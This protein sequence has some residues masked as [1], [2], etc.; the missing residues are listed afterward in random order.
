MAPG[1]ASYQAIASEIKTPEGENIK[2]NPLAAPNGVSVLGGVGTSLNPQASV[3]VPQVGGVQASVQPNVPA[4]NAVVAANGPTVAPIALPAPLGSAG[5]ATAVRPEAA[6]EASQES[7]ALPTPQAT[8]AGDG[9]GVAPGVTPAAKSIEGLTQGDSA[10]VLA[11]PKAEKSGVLNWIFD[12]FKGKGSQDG[13]EASEIAPGAAKGAPAQRLA[14]PGDLKANL[15][16]GVPAPANVPSVAPAL[17]PARVYGVV[18]GTALAVAAVTLMSAS[19]VVAL[20]LPIIGWGVGGLL[21]RGQNAPPAEESG[22]ASGT[23]LG[24]IAAAA[25]VAGG[26]MPISYALLL[27]LAGAFIGYRIGSA[28]KPAAR[29]LPRQEKSTSLKMLPP[30]EAEVAAEAQ[31][32][33]A[34]EAALA[35]PEEV[36]KT[37]AAPAAAKAEEQKPVSQPSAGTSAGND[38]TKTSGTPRSYKNLPADAREVGLDK[39]F[40]AKAKAQD[41]A[42]AIAQNAQLVGVAINLEDP[43][44]HWIFTFQSPSQKI[45]VYEKS[46]K[47]EPRQKGEKAS[48]VLWDTRFKNAGNLEAA[49]TSL[50][51]EKHWFKPA[52]VELRPMWKGDPYYVFTDAQGREARVEAP[53]TAPPVAPAAPAKVE[54]PVAAPQPAAVSNPGNGQDKT[55]GSTPRS[56]RNLPADAREIGLDKLFEAKAKAQDRAR[57][58][59]K[60]AQ[61]IGVAINLDNPNAHWIFTFQSKSRKIT[62][63]EKNVKV[64]RLKA[65]EKAKPVLWN[66]RFKKAGGLEAAYTALKSEKHWFKPVRVELRP[67]WNGDPYYLFIDAQG[68]EARV[69]ATAAQPAPAPAKTP[70]S[71]RAPPEA[72][73]TTAPGQE[74]KAPEPVAAPAA[75]PPENPPAETK[76]AVQPPAGPKYNAVREDF[77]GFRK[78]VGQTYAKAGEP[79]LGMLPVNASVPRIIEQISRQF[80]IPREKVLEMAAQVGFNEKSPAKVWF[81]IYDRLQQANREQFKKLDHNKYEG[82][83]GGEVFAKTLAL[84]PMPKAW[85]E[86]LRKTEGSYRHL[87]N[88]TY[89]PGL[90]GM[91]IR[92]SEVHK[93]FLGFFVR[94]PYHL[95]DSFVFGYFRQNISFEYLHSTQD[96]LNAASPGSGVKMLEAAVR[97]QAFKGD[98]L[99]GAILG[100]AWGRAANRYLVAPLLSPLLTFLKRRVTMAVFSAVAMGILGAFAPGIAVMSFG[101]TAIPFV[102]PAMVGLAHGIPVAVGSVPLI[103]SLLAPVVGAATMALLKDMV[104]GRLLNTMIL[105]TGM[106]LT[107]VLPNSIASQRIKLQEADPKARISGAQATLKTLGSGEFWWTL[108]KQNW[109]SFVGLVTVGAEIEGIMTYAGGVDAHVTS[110]IGHKFTLLEKIG[111]SIER[112]AGQSPIPFGGAITW[113]NV[114]LLKAENLLHLNISDQVMYAINPKLKH[115]GP[116]GQGASAQ[117]V[118]QMTTHR[119]DQADKATK[120]KDGNVKDS[121]TEFDKDLYTKTPAKIKARIE[122]LMAQSGGLEAEMK[123]VKDWQAFIQKK[124]SADEQ[125]VADIQKQSKPITPEERAQYEALLKELTQKRE[126]GYDKSKLA[127]VHDIKNP[128]AETLPKMQELKALQEYYNSHLVPPSKD[129]PG[130]LD[131]LNVQQASLGALSSHLSDIALN[132]APTRDQGAVPPV[133]PALKD[134]ITAIVDKIEKIRQES[135]GEMANRDAIRQLLAVENKARNRALDDRRSGKDMLALHQNMSRLATVMD[136]ALALNE[137]TAAE[138]AISQMENLLNQ[139]L[140]AIQNS[141]QQNQQ[142][143]NTTNGQLGQVNQWTQAA[144]AVVTSDQASQQTMVTNEAEAGGAVSR[145]GGFQTAISGLIAQIN[146]QDKGQSASAAAEYQR[147]L[148]LLPQVVQW[149]TTGNPNNPSA[150]SLTQFQNLLTQIQSSIATAQSGLNQLPTVPVEFAGALI[151]LIPG[152]APGYSIPPSPSKAQTLQLLADRKTYWTGQMGTIQ[153][154]LNTITA[155]MNPANTATTTDEFGNVTPQSLPVWLQQEQTLLGTSQGQAQTMLAQIDQLAADVNVKLGASLPPLS[156]LPLAQLQTALQ[157]Y[158]TQV[159]AVNVPVNE[160]PAQHAASLEILYIAQLMPQAAHNVINWS[161]ASATITQINSAMA[162]T[163]PQAKSKLTEMVTMFQNILSDDAQDVAFVNGTSGETNQQ[164]VNRKTN[165]LQ[166]E[167]LPPLNDAQALL[168][169]VL[170]PYQQSSIQSAQAGQPLSQLFNAQLTLI[171]QSTNLYNQTIPWAIASHG[172]TYGNQ[173]ASLASIAAWRAQLQ[174]N[175]SNTDPNNLGLLQYQTEIQN[176]VNPNFAGTEVLYGETQPYSLPKKIAQY[177]GEMVT[178]AAAINADDAQINSILTQIQTVSNGQYNMQSYL[179]PTGITSD[180]AG[181]AKVQALVNASTIPNLAAQ[182]KTIGNSAN[183]SGGIS[184]PVGGGGGAVPVGTQPPITVSNQQKIALL[185]LD[186]AR[187]LAPSSLQVQNPSD[188]SASYAVARFLYSNAVVTSA[189]NYMAPGGEIQ[190]AT[191]F[192]NDGIKAVNDAI[193]NTQSDQSY[194]TSN[195]SSESPD[196]VYQREVASY[197]ELDN[198]LKEGIAFFGYLTTQDQGAFATINQINTYYTSLQ[199]IYQGGQSANAGEIQAYQQMTQALQSTLTTLQADQAKVLAY[200]S[201]LDDPHDSA[202]RRINETI[203]TLQDKTRAVLEQNIK[204][205]DLQDQ[206]TRSEDVMKSDLTQV[207]EQQDMLKEILAKNDLQDKLPPELVARIDKLRI[208]QGMW[209]MGSGSGPGDTSAIVIKKSDFGRFVDSV[210][211]LFAAQNPDQNI[212]ALRTQI[213]SNPTSLAGLIPDSKV[214]DFGDTADGFYMVYQ[215]NFSSPGGLN[216]GS[217]VTMG[218][219]AKV[220]GNNL[221]VSGYQF[222][223]PP[224]AA[225]VDGVNNA[226]YGDKGVEVQIESLQGKNWVNYLNIDFHKFGLDVPVDNQ[227][228]S[229]ATLSR[230]MIFD[231][232]AVMLFNNK[233]YVGLAGFGDVAMADAANQPY[234]YGGNIRASLK[235]N[236]VMSL[237]AEQQVLFAKDPRT[238]MEQVNL[239]FTGYN[240]DLNNPFNIY[241]QGANKDYERTQV[242]P[243]FNI[244]RLIQGASNSGQ[245]PPDTFTLDLFAARTTGTDDI[246]QNSLGATVIKG[247]TIRNDDGKPIVQIANK[248]TGEVGQ[249]YNDVSDQLSVTLPNQGIVISGQGEILGTSQAYYGQIAKKMGD[250]S[251]ISVGYGSPY[252]GMNNRLSLSMNTGFTLG[253]LWQSVVDNSKESLKGGETL[254]AYNSALDDFFKPKPEDKSSKNIAELKHVFEQDVAQKLLQQNIGTLTKDIE[255]LRKAGAVMDN[256][257][258][259]AMVGWVSNPI[260]ND[261]TEL[262]TGGGFMAGTQTTLTLNKTQKALIEAKSQNLYQDGLELQSRMLALTQEWQQTVAQIAQAQWDLKMDGFIVQNAPNEALRKDAQVKASEATE[263]LHQAIVHYN[264]ISGRNATD[265]TP[266]DNL[267]SAD[268]EKLMGEI[269]KTIAAPDRLKEILHS[270]DPDQLKKA[271]GEGGYDVL[272]GDDKVLK[273]RYGAN[274]FNLVDWLPFIDKFSIGLGTQLQDAMANQL[275]TVGVSVRLPF[276][277]PTSKASDHAYIL[278]TKATIEQMKQAYDDRRLQTEAEIEQA[279]LW[280]LSS[281]AARPA[282]PS[283]IADLGNAI[284]A[285]RNGLI[286]PTQLRQSFESWHW[287]VTTILDADA[288]A[289]VAGAAASLDD[290]FS[291]AAPLD[292]NTVHIGSLDQAYAAAAGRAHSLK[293]VGLR[294]QAAAEMTDA[295]SHRI[296]KAFLTLSVGPGLA[297][298]GVGLMPSLS[299]TGY[300]VTPILGFEFKPEELK[301][302]QLQEGKG[303][304]GYYKALEQKLRAAMAVSFYQNIVAFDQTTK[305]YNVIHDQLIPGLE[306]ELAQVKARGGSETE[307]VAAQKKLDDAQMRLQQSLLAFQQSKATINYLLGRNADS[308]VS[309]DITPDQALASLRQILAVDNPMVADRKVLDSRVEVAQAVEV[310]ADKDLKTEQVALEPISIVVRSFGRLLNA[311]GGDAIGNPDLV[312]AARIQTLTEQRARDDYEHNRQTDLARNQAALTTIQA[313][314]EAINRGGQSGP[315]TALTKAA[316]EAQ[317]SSVEAN[318]IAL[319]GG[320]GAPAPIYA[321]PPT[322]FLGLKSGL[323]QKERDLS[324]KAPQDPVELMDPEKLIHQAQG[325]ARYYYAKETIGRVPID[326]SYLEGWIEVRLK[327]PDTSPEVLLALAKLRQEKSDR[328]YKN[329]LD[330]ATSKAD[331][332]LQDF[333]ANV[334]LLRWVDA[335]KP[336]GAMMKQADQK[337][338]DEYRREISDRLKAEAS[339]ISAVLGLDPNTPVDQL[340]A[341][342]PYDSAGAQNIDALSDKL[343]G[344]IEKS[345]IDRVRQILFDG[346]L[347]ASFGN[348]D[349]LMNQIKANTIAER[350]SYKGFTPVAAYGMFR[351]TQVGGVVLEAPDPRDIQKGLENVL[352]DVLRKDLQSSGRLQQLSLQMNQLMSRVEDGSHE[353]ERKRDLIKAD[354]AD[355]KAQMGRGDL[356]EAEKSRQRLVQAWIDF[357]DQMVQTKADFI[358]LVTE[359][360]AL[361]QGR[362]TPLRPYAPSPDLPMPSL[363]HDPKA[364][365]MSYWADRLVDSDFAAGLA[366]VIDK[367]PPDDA[368]PAVRTQFQK[369]RDDIAARAAVYRSAKIMGDMVDGKD[370]TPAEKLDLLTRNDSE[371]KREALQSDLSVLLKLLEQQGELTSANKGWAVLSGFLQADINKQETADGQQRTDAIGAA[372][373]MRDAFWHAVPAPY[374][375]EGAFT[376]LEAK[377]NDLAEARQSLLEKYLTDTDNNPNT[378]VLKDMAL[379][380]YLKAEQA[381]DEELIKTFQKPEVHNDPA[382]YSGLDALYDVRGAI[383]REYDAT[384]S[385]RGLRAID[386]LIMLEKARLSAARYSSRSPSEIDAVAQALYEMQ[387]KRETWLNQSTDLVP[388]YAITNVEE[389]GTRVWK[390]DGWMTQQDIDS[391]L[392]ADE[393]RAIHG[394]KPLLHREDGKL[395]IDE[396]D[397]DG[398]FIATRELVGGVDAAEAQKDAQQK[399]LDQNQASLK[400]YDRMG[401]YD[402]A[403][404]APL[405]PPTLDTGFEKY[406]SDKG[407]TGSDALTKQGLLSDYMKEKGIAPDSEN[408]RALVGLYRA[409]PEGFTADQVFGPNG[410]GMSGRVFFFKAHEDGETSNA[411]HDALNPLA[412]LR[413]SPDK[414]EMVVYTGDRALSRGLFPTLESLKSSDQASLFYPMTLSAQGAHDMV[415]KA[416]EHQNLELRQGW[417]DVKLNGTAFGRVDKADLDFENAKNAIRDDL[418][419]KLI[420][421]GITTSDPRFIGELDKRVAADPRLATAAQGRDAARGKT[422]QVIDLFQTKDDFNAV[423]KAFQNADK[424]LAQARKEMLDAQT[425]EAAA[426]K[427]SD[428]HKKV[429]DQ[430]SLVYQNQQK[431]I[432]LRVA[433]WMVDNKWMDTHSKVKRGD[434]GYDDAFKTELDKLVTQDDEFKKAQETFDPIA[435]A[436]TKAAEAYKAAHAVTDNAAKAEKE[437][438]GILDHSRTWSLYQ[439]DDLA[440]SLDAQGGLVEV[441]GRPVY[442]SAALDEKLG[443]SPVSRTINGELLAAVVD[444]Q[445]RVKDAYTDQRQIDQDLPS[446][447]IKQVAMQG[448]D[449]NVTTDGKTIKPVFR[450]SHYEKMVPDSNDSTKQVAEP[451]QLSRRYMIDRVKNAD[452]KLT[453][454]KYWG[455]MPWNWGNLLL[456]LPR[457]VVGTPVELLT[458][459]DPNQQHYLGRV[460]M[461]RTE[462]GETEHHGFFRSVAGFFDVLDLLPDPVGRFYDPSQFPDKVVIDSPLKPGQ[463]IS[464]KGMRDGDK[465]IHYGTLAVQRLMTQS[466]EDLTTAK[467]RTLSHFQ[468]GV[469]E[470]LIASYRGRASK[471]NGDHNYEESRLSGTVGDPLSPSGI[472]NDKNALEQPGSDGS[473]DIVLSATPGNLAV[474]KVEKRIIVRAGADQYRKQADALGGYPDKVAKDEAAAR[475]AAD[476]L[477]ADLAAAAGVLN[478]DIKDR[479]DLDA[480]TQKVWDKAFTLAW[481][482]HEQEAL[483]ADLARIQAEITSLKGQ[484]GFWGEYLKQLEDALAHRPKP[485]NPNDPNNPTNPTNPNDPNQPLPL[486]SPTSPAGAFWAWVIALFAV[487]SIISAIFWG[488]IRRRRPRPA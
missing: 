5:N 205:H 247:F 448:E 323:E 274:P 142:N 67:T 255:D 119:P 474:D 351:D 309:V 94:F 461:Y 188:T 89:P 336:D 347:P 192:V 355:Y 21:R 137:I 49:Y 390:V 370:F 424:D 121:L 222:A 472:G 237:N 337:G 213:M 376:S 102:G 399:L 483:E 110:L 239:D 375:V 209:E 377:K 475:A 144:Q 394:E 487:A 72:G 126:E 311:L 158:A 276:Y 15:K 398:K 259:Q 35:K 207:Q 109:N 29:R 407:H 186:A 229:Q 120:D 290:Q 273:D 367:L 38:Q 480:A 34:A 168:Q 55:A 177:S 258:V 149:R 406:L 284:R 462:G 91:L 166:N 40:E 37:P 152:E 293:E 84:L 435:K 92:L 282:L 277:D 130:Y 227:V 331:L 116:A 322:S 404:G 325:F 240:P 176:R 182:L 354:E 391:Q 43:N 25:L 181:A 44:S 426:K 132:R 294:E 179:L 469:E 220:W 315:E 410:L 437:A 51:S 46:I 257:R 131:Q 327:S 450:L 155:M 191:K 108:T 175:L 334:S 356:G 242:G 138:K 201:Q 423:K 477:K 471:A 397:K 307:V 169:N 350:M 184:I 403:L 145:F 466:E 385:G 362:S 160:T 279:R 281:D 341:L 24:T 417:V 198:F 379:D 409:A 324:A 431:V 117:Q 106:T 140:Q 451:V 103:G 402:F 195:G 223:S 395:F 444:E 12:R 111:A 470:L 314:L 458:G 248:V 306:S 156:N 352:S 146:A 48:P 70:P 464:S 101:L 96:F 266:F 58:I 87:A 90:K 473:S 170:I 457:E 14:A 316:L 206:L 488:I 310:I 384:R 88:R 328:L 190:Q 439:S 125:K 308:P 118:V 59:A 233:L 36:A 287:Y 443:S 261:P 330:G 256:T 211:S 300:P 429:A 215:S 41:R 1:P 112:P 463:N 267:N 219:V 420:K 28:I 349:D 312:A 441:S 178:R 260:S 313:Q 262:A 411:L 98:G 373:A 440:L 245:D 275:L 174:T 449:A 76:P 212:D 139:R 278:E 75:K 185:A 364:E 7:L 393:D 269:R 165:L 412:A 39:L 344:D 343:I 52:R 77:L 217:W 235:L 114:L 366:A 57:S 249:Q 18:F 283:S 244:A 422:Y 453:T 320:E 124:L 4:P 115:V 286:S 64:E 135:Q 299:I 292:A 162:T 147:R 272:N 246:N 304:T 318:I 418:T 339:E 340:I 265:V 151:A 230:L 465:D 446:W 42:R 419:A 187:R 8:T 22:S 200:L 378:F 23:L 95:F 11:N 452:S 31:K 383:Q 295:N 20:A 353:L 133:D 54:T 171:N 9:Q 303:Q 27:P 430:A 81:G 202:L 234:Y 482:I 329:D 53:K 60:S 484:L 104:V 291:T 136:M 460:Y 479:Q 438:E 80:N 358:N 30:S 17:S 143:L 478:G 129:R 392:K 288:K 173:S 326:K 218:N 360:E 228:A 251:T 85:K 82:G 332:L 69:A 361:G 216:T 415:V 66:T 408:G 486:P 73:P 264:I 357:S 231:D 157:T 194:I 204:W 203:D 225:N 210:M 468:G 238:F 342:V 374:G 65:S 100:T 47:V 180:A 476:K 32:K 432:R 387:A 2:S 368:S 456:E 97:Q 280:K 416:Q 298:T 224:E 183:S 105:S 433:K 122:K 436:Y 33:A 335:V 3:A 93:H 45:T 345:Q 297:A 19:P 199:T 371:G 56:Y 172:G 396:Y 425:R 26:I 86:K 154:D 197:T 189:Q 78:V 148:N 363:R 99:F 63:Y 241:A 68:R 254:K 128:A 16:P 485:P 321:A 271:M 442:G 405:A 13:A 232:Y 150:F 263:R 107:N 83:V 6:A 445:G 413:M 164:L 333:Q 113:G 252:V 401:K 71:E 338:H 208:G 270:L 50:K 319:G 296:Q 481:R 414:Y 193:A 421:E 62:V 301:E 302:L 454:T 427:D 467:A 253:Q 305:S 359:L 167:I 372:K 127:E 163:L 381:F 61:L 79:K 196:H 346:G 459:R 134:Q 455:V 447:T 123:A 10:K 243:S 382:M 74:P 221:S 226:P 214:V 236:E 369:L 428:D 365:L 289:T 386:A 250:N 389:N 159:E 141:Q 434:S 388:V 268:L 285:Y 348:E 380:E 161:D 317:R 400:L 153:G